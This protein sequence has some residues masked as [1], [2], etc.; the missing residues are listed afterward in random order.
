[1]VQDE[2]DRERDY[3]G[4]DG[5]GSVAPGPAARLEEGLCGAGADERRYDVGGGGEGE[6]ESSVL[7]AGGVGHEDVEDVGHAVE[8]GPVEDLGLAH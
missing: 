5:E 4:D 2:E 6:D 3:G 7:E 1:M 8:P